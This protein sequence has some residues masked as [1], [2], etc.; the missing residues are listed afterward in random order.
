MNPGPTQWARFY[1]A[2]LGPEPKT[3]KMV[4][5][6]VG[7]DRANICWFVDALRKAGTIYNCGRGTC[8]VT[9]AM[10]TYY[11][12][13]PAYCPDHYPSL[14]SKKAASNEQ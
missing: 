14:F 9:K 12:T 8:R 4:S 13:N 11:T 7:I 10:A 1:R 5:V 6:E 3:M 2:F